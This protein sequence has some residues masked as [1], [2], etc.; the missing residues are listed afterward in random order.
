ML[1]TW[2]NYFVFVDVLKYECEN[3]LLVETSWLYVGINGNYFVFCESFEL[4]MWKQIVAWGNLI[5]CRHQWMIH[6]LATFHGTLIKKL[7]WIFQVM[8]FVKGDFQ[9]KC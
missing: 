6:Q 9:T 4:W 1:Q 7:S 3:K 5:L 8:Q 2:Y